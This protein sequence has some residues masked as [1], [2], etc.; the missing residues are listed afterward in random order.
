MDIIK[1]CPYASFQCGVPVCILEVIPC[2]KVK[3]DQCELVKI[4]NKK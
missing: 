4:I 2:I 3:N 1:K